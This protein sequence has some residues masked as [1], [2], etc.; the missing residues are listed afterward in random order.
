MQ[1]RTMHTATA[2]TI[3]AML[4]STAALAMLLAMATA[5]TADSKKVEE[6]K[7]PFVR[8]TPESLKPKPYDPSWQKRQ[9]ERLKQGMAPNVSRPK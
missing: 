9:E 2:R 3:S 7:S 6:Y 1:W 8:I 5:A 4:T